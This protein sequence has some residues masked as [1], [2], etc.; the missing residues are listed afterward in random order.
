VLL[1]KKYQILSRKI[2]YGSFYILKSIGG[3]VNILYLTVVKVSNVKKE[4]VAFIVLLIFIVLWALF[5]PSPVNTNTPIPY[6][7]VGGMDIQFKD[8]VT[9]PEVRAILQ[10]TNMTMDYSMEY[11]SNATDERYYIMVGKDKISYVRDESRKVKSWT[12]YSHTIDKGNYYLVT[13]P[14]QVIHDINFLAMLDKYNL[15]LKRFIWCTIRFRLNDGH[16]YWIPKEGAIRIKKELEQNEN[17]FSIRLSYL[18]Y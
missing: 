8:G 6:S 11:D 14:E 4:I 1:N 10:K 2:D 7:Q 13:V 3:L 9:E 17:I 18:Y 5:T 16:N 12:E 15:Q